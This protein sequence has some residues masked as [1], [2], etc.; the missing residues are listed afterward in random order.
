M[1]F[2]CVKALAI[3]MELTDLTACKHRLH[4][5][6]GAWPK[7]TTSSFRKAIIFSTATPFQVTPTKDSLARAAG[8]KRAYWL[9]MGKT[10]SVSTA[11]Y[12]AGNDI[13]DLCPIQRIVQGFHNVRSG[14][15]IGYT[16]LECCDLFAAASGQ[17]G[18]KLL[19]A[20]VPAHIGS[21]AIRGFGAI[22]AIARLAGAISTFGLLVPAVRLRGR[23][24]VLAAVRGSAMIRHRSFRSEQTV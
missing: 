15:S 3:V 18:V 9:S 10:A 19:F 5:F 20:L 22:A 14:G 11:D 12:V 6:A 24:R 4:I 2:L 8:G 17:L 23:T 7:P 21:R 13:L 16:C 1:F